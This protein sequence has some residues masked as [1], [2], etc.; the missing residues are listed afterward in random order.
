MLEQTEGCWLSVLEYFTN[1]MI[2]G[3]LA[4]SPQLHPSPCKTSRLCAIHVSM[5]QT[6]QEPNFGYTSS[7]ISIRTSTSRNKPGRHLHALHVIAL[8]S[9]YSTGSPDTGGKLARSVA[10][11]NIL[12]GLHQPLGTPTSIDLF[13]HAQSDHILRS[14]TSN[15][16]T[17][18]QGCWYRNEVE[19]QFDRLIDDWPPVD[20][21]VAGMENEQILYTGL[22]FPVQRGGHCWSLLWRALR[23]MSHACKRV[24][25]LIEQ[26]LLPHPNWFLANQAFIPRSGG[27]QPQ[28]QKL[29]WATAQMENSTIELS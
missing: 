1:S 28:V 2:K 23:H 5:P 25:Y 3:C 15:V 6:C 22:S 7:K 16:H 12:K 4:S 24:L 19:L 18:V 10:G 8:A 26:R 21:L 29:F 11:H 9:K 13:S 20:I 27:A 17:L 14:L